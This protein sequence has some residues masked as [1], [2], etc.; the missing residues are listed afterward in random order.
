M[1]FTLKCVGYN[2]SE[3]CFTIGK[4]YKF[5]DG[6]FYSDRGFNYKHWTDDQFNPEAVIKW[7]DEWYKFELVPNEEIVITHD[8]KTTTATMY[9]GDEKVVATAR[10]APEDKFDFVVG[11]K[12][13]ME[14]LAEKTK[15]V[16]INGFKVGDR[17]NHCGRNGT[18][19]CINNLNC[20][21]VEFDKPVKGVWY[22]HCNG[23]ELIAGKEST[24]RA[25]LW[26]HAYDEGVKHGEVKELYNG[27]V[28][29]IK[30]GTDHWTV[31]K[32]YNVTDGIVF[33]NHGWKYP[34]GGET[35]CDEEDIRHIGGDPFKDIRHNSKNE[36]VPLIEG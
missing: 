5:K 33:S 31:G 29:C 2:S 6:N 25:C 24:K 13:A 21:G 1:T 30:A 16:V 11:A 32:V 3:R 17:V 34:R 18:V 7:F 10:C 12:L 15:E 9:R 36:F 27:K 20:L 28:V 4:T 23:N 26:V 19:I 14:R 8:Y 35:Y 22:H